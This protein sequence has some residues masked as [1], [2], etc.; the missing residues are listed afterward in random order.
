MLIS[1]LFS[2]QYFNTIDAA[3]NYGEGEMVNPLIL[4]HS[5]VYQGEFL[6][7]DSDV[8]ILG[9]GKKLK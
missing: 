2:L 6:V 1:I 9:A 3:Y 8:T 5:G 4:V 7:I